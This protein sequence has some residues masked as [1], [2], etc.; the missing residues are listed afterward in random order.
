MKWENPIWRLLA[1]SSMAVAS[2]PDW[3]TNANR[4]GSALPGAKLAFSPIP[5]TS[6]PMQFGPKMRS[7]QGRAASSMACSSVRP[8]AVCNCLSPAVMTM[9]ERVPFRP[10]A[11]IRPGTACGGVQIT[12]RSGAAGSASTLAQTG[13][14]HM[15]V[16]RGFTGQIA[17]LK[18]PL[19]RF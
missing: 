10:N 7:N 8:S 18:P 4:P 6:A 2:A 12:A 17:P 5:G 16:W 13:S 3:V 14:P 19:S 9:A 11:S 15:L 1:Q